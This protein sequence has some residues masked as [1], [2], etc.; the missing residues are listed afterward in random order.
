MELSTKIDIVK[1]IRTNANLPEEL[2]DKVV[3]KNL[4][5]DDFEILIK[6]MFMG[7][8]QWPDEKFYAIYK[9]MIKFVTPKI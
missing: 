8:R 2:P 5:K 1:G 9:R 6:G 4:T 7:G 3:A